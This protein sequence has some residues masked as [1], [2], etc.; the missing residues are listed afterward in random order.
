MVRK[1][2]H[3]VC[4]KNCLPG[5]KPS[6]SLIFEGKKKRSGFGPIKDE[7]DPSSDPS[8]DD[9]DDDGDV[10]NSASDSV[11]NSRGVLVEASHSWSA[12]G[13]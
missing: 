11:I 6:G 1:E 5:I 9:D 10:E 12:N 3:T 13:Q 2:I 7:D 8:Y 4:R